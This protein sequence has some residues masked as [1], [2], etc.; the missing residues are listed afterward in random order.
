MTIKEIIKKKAPLVEISEDNEHIDLVLPL[1]STIWYAHTKCSDV[2]SR[3]KKNG[4]IEGD[5]G[6]VN[7]MERETYDI[8][9]ATGATCH[10]LIHGVK[11]T[12][13]T[14]HNLGDVSKGWF[15]TYFPTKASALKIT[16][17]AIMERRN[18]LEKNGIPWGR[19]SEQVRHHDYLMRWTK[20]PDERGALS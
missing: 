13:L 17:E 2:C 11:S 7:F 14:L 20:S 8:R 1:G 4:H 18:V 5:I 10:T 12:T 3:N 16:K 6:T 15:T 19:D 9:C